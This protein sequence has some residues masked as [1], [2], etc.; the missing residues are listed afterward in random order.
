MH[1]RT[2]IFDVGISFNVDHAK[3]ILRYGRIERTCVYQTAN[4]NFQKGYFCISSI[5]E[6][7]K[8]FIELLK[9]PHFK[10]N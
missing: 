4:L 7:K 8:F 1:T 5:Y 9:A 3:I 6:Y 10:V 2:Y